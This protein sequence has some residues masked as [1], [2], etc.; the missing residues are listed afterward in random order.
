MLAVNVQPKEFCQNPWRRFE[1]IDRLE[2]RH[3]REAGG[4]VGPFSQQQHR[5][6]VS[7]AA[8]HRDNERAQQ[9]RPIDAA[10]ACHQPKQ[11]PGFGGFNRH[12]WV[13]RQ[14]RHRPSQQAQQHRRPGGVVAGFK[15]QIQVKSTQQLA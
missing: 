3:N 9:L 4:T 14:P 8:C 10:H 13:R 12:T 11:V 6:K 5:Q 15:F 7:R 1:V 2:E